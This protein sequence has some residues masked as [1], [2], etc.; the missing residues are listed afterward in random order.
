MTFEELTVKDRVLFFLLDFPIDNMLDPIDMDAEF[1]VK[2]LPHDITQEGIAESV[3]IRWNHAS[4]ALKELRHMNLVEQKKSNIEGGRRVRFVYFLSTEGY[5]VANEVASRVNNEEFQI[6][7]DGTLEHMTFSQIY[8]IYGAEIPTF[9]FFIRFEKVFSNIVTE[10]D[11]IE[12]ISLKSV[13]DEIGRIN[14]HISLPEIKIVGRE[15]ELGLLEDLIDNGPNTIV[16][17]GLPGMGKTSLISSFLST[18]YGYETIYYPIHEWDSARSILVV[19]SKFLND[20]N[21]ARLMDYLKAGLHDGDVDGIQHFD[22]WEV[23]QIISEDLSG[24]NVIIVFD[25]YQKANEDTKRLI[26]MIFTIVSSSDDLHMCV[27]SRLSP[28]FYGQK[29]VIAEKKVYEMHLGGIDYTSMKSLLEERGIIDP[30]HYP[31]IYQV[32][33][34]HPLAIDL[35]GGTDGLDGASNLSTYVKDEI[36]NNLSPDLRSFLRKVAVYRKPISIDLITRTEEDIDILF[37]L[38]SLSLIAETGSEIAL[39]DMIRGVIYEGI[40]E[41]MRRDLHIEAAKSLSE[42]RFEDQVEAFYHYMYGKSFSK[43]IE[44]LNEFL[45]RFIEYGYVGEIQEIIENFVD[46]IDLEWLSRF[47]IFRLETHLSLGEYHETKEIIKSI[48][49][50]SLSEYDKFKYKG[51]MIIGRGYYYEGQFDKCIAMMDEIIVDNEFVTPMNR[52]EALHWKGKA[53]TRLGKKDQGE[54]AFKEAIVLAK[55]EKDNILE[56]K[57]LMARSFI[58]DEN[59]NCALEAARIF[60]E[61]GALYNLAEALNYVGRLYYRQGDL[62]SAK[63]NWIRGIEIGLST[64]NYRLTAVMQYNLASVYIESSDFSKALEY[65]KESTRTFYNVHFASG[66]I[67]SK[68]GYGSFYAMRGDYQIAERFLNMGE[69]IARE[70]NDEKALELVFEEKCN[71]YS[72]SGDKRRLKQYSDQLKQLQS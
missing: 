1:V 33:G 37:R 7:K 29:D 26:S 36:M 32:T 22:L 16:I 9:E 57:V 70:L 8:R 48:E 60:E 14:H 71:L 31:T 51:K 30:S 42:S 43:G 15:N 46:V 12:N 62:H 6:L 3:G 67:Y 19:L 52:A 4:R 50:N 69:E 20:I 65:L 23:H 25:D 38:I 10:G 58:T 18:Y 21:K 63:R 54:D 68:V 5:T 53:F 64:G 35:I 24:E 49:S 47:N 28:E 41:S 34:G 11:L 45:P 56:G 61:E 40:P 66:F 44:L 55:G 39:H 27:L 17:I 59:L 72:I 2:S 13:I